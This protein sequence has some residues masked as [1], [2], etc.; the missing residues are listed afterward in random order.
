[1]VNYYRDMWPHQAHI[2]TP[3]TSQ[4]GAPNKG[5]PQQQYVWT[6]EMQAAFNQMKALMAMDILCTYP[7]HNKPFHIY[8]NAS[9]YQPG[10]CI[11][12]NNQPVAYYS[13]KMNN[14]QRN[15]SSVDKE[16]LSIVMTL[17][18]FWSMLLGAELHI[19]TEHKNILNIGDSSQRRLQWISY[20]NYDVTELH[21]VEGSAN[22]VADTFSR[23]SQKDTPVSPAVGKKQPAEHS[24]NKDDVNETPLDNFFSWV[25]NREM[26]EC[27]KCLSDEECYLNLPDNMIDTN[28]LDME[29]I[30]EQQGAD[31]ALLQHATKNADQYMR[32]CIGT[33]DDILCYIKPGDPP[34]NWK[35]ALPKSLLQPT[36][37]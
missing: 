32:K 34:N 31:D 11:M 14:A 2:L 4:T 6:E 7:N 17:R 21:Y 24:I 37:K 27:F 23:L 1:M 8:T 3:L 30:K 22:S 5:Q 19:H 36:I 28:L 18:K 35:I 13:K 16:L 20:V 29:N 26:F 12:Q 15:Y 25:D 9:D 10:S 33:I